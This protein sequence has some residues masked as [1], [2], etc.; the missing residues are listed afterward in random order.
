MILNFEDIVLTP[1]KCVVKSRSECDTSTTLGKHTFEVP[2]VCANMKSVLTPEICK[3][4]D[5]NN[6]FYIYHRI[7]GTADVKKFVNFAQDFNIVSISVGVGKKW[8]TLVRSLK[9]S[10]LKVDYFTVDVAHSHA[11]YILPVLRTI[12][13]F[14]PDSYIICGNGCTAE[15][16]QWLESFNLVDCI[17]VGIG[18]SKSCRTREYTGFGS[19]TLGS[20][21]ECNDASQKDVMSDGG[22]TIKGDTVYIGDIAKA[23]AFGADWVMSGALFSKCIDS[24]SVIH[25]YYG[26]ASKE[27]KGSDHVEGEVVKVESNGLHI[28]EMMKLIQQSLRSSISY[29]GKQSVHQLFDIP[30]KIIGN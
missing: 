15:W 16:V 2:V 29:A 26:N 5:K 11:D 24:P 7:D 3:T 30:Y 19:S 14:Y 13:K 20:L 4:F 25:G 28:E 1:Q 21:K 9:K 8:Q 23:F 6:W 27:A 22:I 12:R 17:K 10:E 18:V